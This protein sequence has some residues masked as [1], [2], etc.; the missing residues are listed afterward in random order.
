MSKILVLR[1]PEM[2]GKH[3]I[4]NCLALHQRI[5]HM[6]YAHAKDKMQG[7]HTRLQSFAVSM[8]AAVTTMRKN[9]HFEYNS[10]NGNESYH[11]TNKAIFWSAIQKQNHYYPVFED[12]TNL[13]QYEKFDQVHIRSVNTK[14]LMDR[15][16]TKDWSMKP[17][18]GV[19]TIDFDM[20][21]IL[22]ADQ[23][24]KEITKV[25]DYLQ[26]D[27]IDSEQIKL[28]LSVWL[29]GVDIVSDVGY[30]KE[31]QYSEKQVLQQI[32]IDGAKDNI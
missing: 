25:T 2:A 5:L 4:A 1:F 14:W 19:D 18:K 32:K 13:A 10:F 20:S 15:R 23:F 8:Q 9:V 6:D 11:K 12:N 16:N 28:L 24:C 3:F 30:T 27:P 17:I 26:F 31:T 29:L 21:T 22:D 7:K